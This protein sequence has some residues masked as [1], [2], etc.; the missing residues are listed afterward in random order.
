ML[1]VLEGESRIFSQF[2]GVGGPLSKKF[3]LEF[4]MGEWRA[5][6][7][8]SPILQVFMPNLLKLREARKKRR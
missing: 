8:L 7:K 1:D 5:A 6:M 4:V 3:S 2:S